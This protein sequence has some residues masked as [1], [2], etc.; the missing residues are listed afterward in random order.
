MM[1]KPLKKSFSQEY[2]N[3]QDRSSP[4]LVKKSFTQNYDENG[5]PQK[6]FAEEED[7][8][9][10]LIEEEEE[11][12]LPA[13]K[14]V[15]TKEM[16]QEFAVRS[17]MT[18]KAEPV[19]IRIDKFE[20]SMKVFHAIRSQISEIESLVKETKDIKSKEEQELASWEKE[21]Q[22]IKNEI[23]KVNNDIFSRVE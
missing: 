8:E 4:K 3:Y 18:K 14:P 6:S 19:F 23:D 12:K 20:E 21:I 1:P 22:K 16:P 15:K 13:K 9:E 17:Y 11:E 2:E 7:G 5:M 10:P